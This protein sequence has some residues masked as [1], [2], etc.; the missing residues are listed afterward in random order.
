MK[1][2]NYISGLLALRREINSRIDTEIEN[3]IKG[4]GNSRGFKESITYVVEESPVL[5]G[6]Y[7]EDETSMR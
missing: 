3:T 4:R 2:N 1:N 6:R 5:N 7:R